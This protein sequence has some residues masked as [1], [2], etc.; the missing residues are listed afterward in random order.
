[1]RA[2]SSGE[3]STS[4]IKLARRAHA[5]DGPT[6]DLVLGHLELEV[7]VDGAGGQETWMRGALGGFERFAGG[8]DVV[9]DC[10]G[11]GRR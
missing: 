6:D 11:P 3:N 1:M 9:L 7:A 5:V 10:S 8:V 2:A 4:S